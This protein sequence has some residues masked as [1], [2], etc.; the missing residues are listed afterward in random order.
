[1]CGWRI[2]TIDAEVAVWFYVRLEAMSDFVLDWSG[3]MYVGL[4]RVDRSAPLTG[5]DRPNSPAQEPEVTFCALYQLV[6]R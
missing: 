5:P 2:G 1:M 6:T 4:Q 3:L